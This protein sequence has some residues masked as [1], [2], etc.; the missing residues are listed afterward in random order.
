LRDIEFP[1]DADFPELRVDD[2]AVRAD[3][4]KRFRGRFAGEIAGVPA[5]D[6]ERQVLENLERCPALMIKAPHDVL[7]FLELQIL[8]RPVQ[9]RSAFLEAVTQR[10]LNAIDDWSAT[11]RLDFIFKHVA[12]RG[13]PVVEPD[14]GP[15]I[16]D[17]RPSPV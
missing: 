4:V 2:P 11:K 5:A 8:V 14:L 9:R 3:W 12:R 16:V 17:G 15:W 6:V 13:V 7:R 1:P 10:V